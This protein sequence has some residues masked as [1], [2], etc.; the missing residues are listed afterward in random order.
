MNMESAIV[1]EVFSLGFHVRKVVSS[2]RER[3]RY[4]SNWPRMNYVMA[5][6]CG[7]LLFFCVKK[8]IY[9]FWTFLFTHTSHTHSY[10]LTHA[11][12][13]TKCIRFFFVILTIHP[14][15]TFSETG[16]HFCEVETKSEEIPKSGR[17]YSK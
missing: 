11:H 2:F 4:I 15:K 16:Y 3:S 17:K 7:W 10:S 6:M 1:W 5:S 9:I 14:R 13:I 12:K 8:N